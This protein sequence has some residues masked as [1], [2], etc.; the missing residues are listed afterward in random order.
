MCVKEN[1][2]LTVVLKVDFTQ[3]L[4]QQGERDFGINLGSIPNTMGTVG[5]YSQGVGWRNWQM[6]NYQEV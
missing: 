2:S 5:I 3:E 6:E 4:W 1:Q